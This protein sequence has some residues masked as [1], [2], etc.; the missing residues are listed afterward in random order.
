MAGHSET[1]HQ[2]IRTSL[3]LAAIFGVLHLAQRTDILSDVLR[4]FV[5]SL[6][7]LFGLPATQ[8][9]DQLLIGRLAIPWSRDCAGLNVLGILWALTIW[10]NRSEPRLGRYALR[11]LLAV[12]AAFAANV[13]RILTLIA[14]RHFFYPAIESPQLH[15]FMGFLWLV[16]IVWFFCPRGNRGLSRYATETLQLAA[17]LSLLAPLISAPGGNLVALCTLLLLADTHFNPAATRR[18]GLALSLW[19]FAALMI[20]ASSMESLW[21]PWLVACPAF[22]SFRL[23][24]AFPG[25]LLLA[26]TVPLVAMHNV[27]QWIILAAV[28]VQLWLWKKATTPV[29]EKAAESEAMVRGPGSGWAVAVGASLLIPFLAAPVYGLFVQQGTPPNAAMP[30][31][32][33]AHAYA[34]RLLGQPQDLELVWFEPTGEGRHHTLEVC[35]KYRGVTLQPASVAGVQTDGKRWMRE[36]FLLRSGLVLNYEDYLRRTFLPFSGAGIHVIASSPTNAMSAE[37]FSRFTEQSARYLEGCNSPNPPV[38]QNS[39][40]RAPEGHPR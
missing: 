39:S 3:S 28:A 2:V 4:P 22:T 23:A 35:M 7:H 38:G 15:Y 20:G 1:R 17:G 14:Y 26:G 27:G 18:P 12:P 16:P 36:F 34:V 11:L 31:D 5:A 25:I 29:S 24:T 6:L 13:A 40:A 30:R 9:D 8:G 33:G 37:S 19:L 32:L 10:T 21:L